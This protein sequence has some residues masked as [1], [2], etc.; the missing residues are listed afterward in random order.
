MKAK[1]NCESIVRKLVDNGFEYEIP[2]RILE[3]AIKSIR[4]CIDPR[5]VDKWIEAMLVFGYLTLSR[6][7]VYLLD[8]VA[9]VNCKKREE[10]T[11]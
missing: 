2:R 5:T 4:E 1:Q 7:N 10:I 8:R 6:P 3:Q 11:R 9:V